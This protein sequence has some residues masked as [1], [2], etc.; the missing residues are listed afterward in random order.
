M[1]EECYRKYDNF[2]ILLHLK[3]KD[4]IDLLKIIQQKFNNSVIMSKTK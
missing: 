4:F 1:K 2:F 3:E